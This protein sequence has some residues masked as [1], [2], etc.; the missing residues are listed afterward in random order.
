MNK[1]ILAVMITTML[2]IAGAKCFGQNMDSRVRA[3]QGEWQCIEAFEMDL[4]KPPYAERWEMT[5]KFEGNNYFAV[6]RNLQDGSSQVET[7]T[8]TVVGDSLVM[9]SA[10]QSEAWSY[11]IRGNILTVSNKGESM[12]FRKR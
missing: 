5:W 11:S 7:S 8:F 2:F 12:T 3:L 9:T 10:G 1:K 4:T 6:M